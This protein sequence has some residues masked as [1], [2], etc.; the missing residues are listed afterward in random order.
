MVYEKAV[1]ALQLLII[2][3]IYQKD[4]L[5]KENKLKTDNGN[6]EIPLDTYTDANN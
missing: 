3:R 6:K 4:L 5:N 1:F 2:V